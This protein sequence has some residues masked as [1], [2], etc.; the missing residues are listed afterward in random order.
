M[1]AYIASVLIAFIV[2][3]VLTALGYDVRRKDA[4]P[5]TW[6]DGVVLGIAVLMLTVGA[7]AIVKIFFERELP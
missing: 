3:A 6:R 2:L 4:L 7:T 5:M 1:R